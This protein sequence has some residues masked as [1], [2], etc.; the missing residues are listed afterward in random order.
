MD[1]SHIRNIS[2]SLIKMS[3]NSIQNK[4]GVNNNYNNSYRNKIR[5]KLGRCWLII[6]KLKNEI[7]SS[8]SEFLIDFFNENLL[9]EYY[10]MNFTA[11]E[12]F[13]F[14]VEEIGENEKNLGGGNIKEVKNSK[15]GRNIAN[16]NKTDTLN[17]NL[18]FNIKFNLQS[19]LNKIVPYLFHYSKMTSNDIISEEMGGRQYSNK[20]KSKNNSNS[21]S[22]NNSNNISA[23]LNSNLNSII[24]GESQKC[25]QLR[26]VL[27]HLPLI[28]CQEVP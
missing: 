2:D 1:S 21:A 22:N 6:V 17:F 18:N 27:G 13:L 12:Y 15:E 20:S 4:I 5:Y 11:T 7:L 3:Q 16:N 19:Q 23:N 14:I 8:L 26:N 10:E 24:N 25:S 9:F 28:D